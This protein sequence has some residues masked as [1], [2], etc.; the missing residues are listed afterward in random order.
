MNKPKDAV[1]DSAMKWKPH[2]SIVASFPTP[3]SVISLPD[4]ILAIWP[5]SPAVPPLPVELYKVK[6]EI[7]GVEFAKNISPK[8]LILDGQQRL[9]AIYGAMY[10]IGQPVS[11]KKGKSSEERYYYLDIEKVLEDSNDTVDL[12]VVF[13]NKSTSTSSGGGSGGGSSS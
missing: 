12:K 8:N 10:N 1:D 5:L 11:L 9:T 3:S 2:P 4:F 7:S 6:P 13:K